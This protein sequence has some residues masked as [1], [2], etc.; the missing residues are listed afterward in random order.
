MPACPKA[1]CC[2]C[3][4]FGLLRLLAGRRPHA[5]RAF[6]VWPGGYT[7]PRRG[8]LPRRLVAALSDGFS[9]LPRPRGE[10]VAHSPQPFR[11][12]PSPLSEACPLLRCRPSGRF[13]AAPLAREKLDARSPRPFSRLPFPLSVACPLL[14]C[15]PSGRFLPLP[16]P[17]ASRIPVPPRLFR[18]LP[19]PLRGH[20]PLGLP[21]VRLAFP[22]WPGG[23]TL[24]RRGRLPLHFATLAFADAPH[25]PANRTA[26][27]AGSRW[28]A[29]RV[30][31]Q[32]ISSARFPETWRGMAI[33]LALPKCFRRAFFPKIG[34]QPQ[35]IAPSP[36]DPSSFSPA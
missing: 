36:A 27:A 11:R 29:L 8:R 35:H 12:L 23:Y 7:L 18:R 31:W 33:S 10:P 16:Q 13:F 19:S 15:I 28:L 3:S 26:F 6:F 9:P 30:G 17:E 32:K 22:V 1:S 5:R 21:H 2:A 34:Q 14:R 4:C 20:T 25:V 24:P